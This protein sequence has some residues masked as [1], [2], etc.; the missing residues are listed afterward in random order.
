MKSAALFLSSLGLGFT[1]LALPGCPPVANSDAQQI[2]RGTAL[3][4]AI[5]LLQ[6]EARST[7]PDLRANCLEALQPL[8]DERSLDVIGQGLHDSDWTV[9]FAAVMVAGHRK[10]Q[11]FK[12]VLQQMAVTDTNN[13]VQIAAIYAL[14][15]LGDTHNMGRLAE[16]LG[17]TDVAQRANT[18]LALGLLGDKSAIP[19]L[20]AHAKDPEPRAKFEITAALARLGEPS[21][22]TALVAFSVSKY[23]DDR[24][25]AMATWPDVHSPDAADVLLSGLQDPMP[26]LTNPSPQIELM[27]DSIRLTA[28]RSL[29][30]MGNRAGL[31]GAMLYRRHPQPAI[32]SLAAMALGEILQPSESKVLVDMM[33][34]PDEH[35]RVA[36]AAAIV[37]LFTRDRPSASRP[38][39]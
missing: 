26:G 34:D 22:V 33:K 23:V 15:R 35:V 2:A 9:R 8:S 25:F 24:I 29:G 7:E 6:V 14:A 20:L 4:K 19:L 18:A 13:N 3:D 27:T 32:R 10:A 39:R 28:A 12:P 30:K 31:D 11:G 36:A 1:L 37:N 17:S 5:V 21:A 38:A 16:T